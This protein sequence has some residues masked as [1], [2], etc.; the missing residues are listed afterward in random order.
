MP[1]TEELITALVDRASPGDGSAKP[2]P[3]AQCERMPLTDETKRVL[4]EECRALTAYLVGALPSAY[5]EEQYVRAAHVHGVAFDE[6]FSCFDRVTV[7]LARSNRLAAR[8]ADAYCGLLH[9]RGVLRR[10]LIVLSAILEHVAPTSEAF[11]KVETRGLALTVL[12]L[13][14]HGVLSTL[15]L[16]LGVVVLLPTK[17]VC[18]LSARSAQGTR[19]AQ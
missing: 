19:S 6:N 3:A 17:L 11:D 12:A 13:A 7:R 5:T 14:G 16:L 15:S 4:R 8:A 9:R 10:K 1:S 18:A 2:A